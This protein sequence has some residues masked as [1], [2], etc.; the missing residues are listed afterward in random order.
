MIYENSVKFTMNQTP[1]HM[2]CLQ[3]KKWRKNN[4]C[5]PERNTLG[6]P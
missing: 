3:V 2:D 5:L 4:G 6:Q 1:F